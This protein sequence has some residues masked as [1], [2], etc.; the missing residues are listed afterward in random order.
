MCWTPKPGA[1]RPPKAEFS[2]RP[3]PQASLGWRRAVGIKARAPF[4]APPSRDCALHRPASLHGL[5]WLHLLDS[6][7]LVHL[8]IGLLAQPLYFWKPAL[9]N[10]ILSPRHRLAGTLFSP[11]SKSS[12]LSCPLPSAGITVPAIKITLSELHGKN[13]FTLG[14][15][16]QPTGQTRQ[17]RAPRARFHL[18]DLPPSLGG[19]GIFPISSHTWTHRTDTHA[20]PPTPGPP[21]APPG[22]HLPPASSPLSPPS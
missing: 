22:A 7:S 15:P 19:R 8:A 5:P 21:I 10:H 20:C 12:S 6:V 14:L 2:L 11:Q 1:L 4:E 18:T 17:L 9:D 16:D 3:P 13:H